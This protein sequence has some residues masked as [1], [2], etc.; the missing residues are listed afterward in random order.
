MTTQVLIQRQTMPSAAP[1]QVIA[2]ERGFRFVSIASLIDRPPGRHESRAGALGAR[3]RLRRAS[4]G[5][6][7]DAGA[8]GRTAALDPAAGGDSNQ[9]RVMADRQADQRMP[10]PGPGDERKQRV[11]ADDD[12]QHPERAVDPEA[13]PEAG[14]VE[15]DRE[16]HDRDVGG[17][18]E[19]G[20]EP[21]V[22]ARRLDGDEQDH[23]REDEPERRQEPCSAPDPEGPLVAEFAAAADHR[24]EED[25]AADDEEDVEAVAEDR[26][27]RD[28]GVAARMGGEEPR[29]ADEVDEHDAERAK[30]RKPLTGRT[31]GARPAAAGRD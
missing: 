7:G 28:A 17:E 27:D 3:R 2:C 8:R 11:E 4:A 5:T 24:Q 20:R 14:V 1:V 6:S 26:P 23:D 18:L 31:R 30:T 19:H 29:D 16:L 10:V 15:L 25:E 21:V 9:R 22:G 12:R 13:D